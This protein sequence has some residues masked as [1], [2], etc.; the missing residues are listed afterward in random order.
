[1]RLV[2]LLSV[3][4]IYLCIF[5]FNSGWLNGSATEKGLSQHV[6]N[7]QTYIIPLMKING[8]QVRPEDLIE[9]P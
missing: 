2:K 4:G 3:A 6:Q 1:M 9:S 7:T 8:I 5:A